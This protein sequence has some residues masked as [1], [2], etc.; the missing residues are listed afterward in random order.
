[1]DRSISSNACLLTNL[2]I[3]WEDAVFNIFF[4][5]TEAG[6][7]VPRARVPWRL[8]AYDG[9]EV[10]FDSVQRIATKKIDGHRSSVDC[11][12]EPMDFKGL[13]PLLGARS[14]TTK[15]GSS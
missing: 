12:T 7:H 3:H 2:I 6:R 1:M 9:E 10:R 13:K 14:S 8:G 5:V 4:S 11:L 15:R